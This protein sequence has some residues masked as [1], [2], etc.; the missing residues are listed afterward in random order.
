MF[1]ID[2]F[3]KTVW[4]REDE[5]FKKLEGKI[6]IP[7]DLLKK[8]DWVR[9]KRKSDF[10]KIPDKGGCYW[11]WTNESI[12]HRLHKNRLPKKIAKGE[13]IYNGI[14]KDNVRLR[15]KH[16]LLGNEE[17]GWSGVSIDIYFGRSSS[18]RKKAFSSEL[19]TKVPCITFLDRDNSE[20]F[21]PIRSKEFLLKLNLSREERKFVE[22][23]NWKNFYF[24]NG[25]NI[26]GKKHKKYNFKAY[27]ITGLRS[28][29]LEY[30]EKKWRRRYGLPKLCSYTTGR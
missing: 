10:E 4:K 6:K 8:V 13:I 7:N 18:H 15:I 16:H 17:Q 24:T 21:V 23:N 20:R 30:I 11:L 22:R 1:V 19:K 28:L 26:F 9:L 27:Y 25:I 5:K 14:A 29:Y 2:S 3:S 12:K